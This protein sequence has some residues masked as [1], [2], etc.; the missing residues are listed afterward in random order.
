MHLDMSRYIF[1]Y[2]K[3]TSNKANIIIIVIDEF[4]LLE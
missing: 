2:H 4:I 3:H 1:G